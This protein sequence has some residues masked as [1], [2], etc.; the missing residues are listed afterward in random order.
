MGLDSTGSNPVF[1]NISLNAYSDFLNQFLMC[2][3]R[4][5]LYAETR[6]TSS[7]KR[8]ARIFISLNLL[9]RIHKTHEDTWRLFPSYGS[10]RRTKRIVKVYNLT[11]SKKVLSLQALRILNINC[12]FSHYIIETPKG[13]MTHK[14]AIKYKTGGFLI[15]A[16]L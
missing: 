1:P 4:N 9:R 2:S 12:P 6:L 15:C 5:R 3:F 11:S 14:T 16:I 7:S 10:T 13:L 8:L